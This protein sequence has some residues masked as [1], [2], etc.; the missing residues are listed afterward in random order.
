MFRAS[1][2]K[3]WNVTADLT[4]PV[5]RAQIAEMSPIL[6]HQSKVRLTDKIPS[7]S[8]TATVTIIC[9]GHQMERTTQ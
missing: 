8:V 4:A 3:T 6:K 2:E 1:V 9:L 5:R 7:F